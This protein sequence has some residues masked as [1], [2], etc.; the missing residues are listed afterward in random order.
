MFGGTDA[1]YTLV[2]GSATVINISSH[3]FTKGLEV[4]FSTAGTGLTGLT[5]QTTYY[6]IPITANS[7]SLA[8]TSALALANWPVVFTSS[9]AGTT[10]H[11][12]T[13]APLAIAGTSSYKWE[14]SN[15]GVNWFDAGQSTVSIPTASFVSTGTVN[16]WDFSPI[17]YA[18]IRLNVKAPSAGGLKLQVIGNGKNSNQ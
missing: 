4:L 9:A 7:I 18:W 2:S 15:D 10:A 16:T 11:T 14:V 12:W 8:T 6:V 5:N 13:L 1:A 3:G 17:D